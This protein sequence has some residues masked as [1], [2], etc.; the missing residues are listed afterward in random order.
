MADWNQISDI[1]D[2]KGDVGNSQEALQR[3]LDRRNSDFE[4]D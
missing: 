3:E 2:V 4:G 1:V